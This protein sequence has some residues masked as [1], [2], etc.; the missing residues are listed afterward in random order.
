M[1]IYKIEYTRKKVSD[2]TI[3]P[4][5]MP[6]QAL[7]FLLEHCFPKKENWREKS[8]LL[9][10]DSANIL[11]GYTLIGVGGFENVTVDIKL[12]LK[13][14]LDCNASS[15]ILV[16]NHPANNVLPS[17]ADIVQTGKLKKALGLVDIKLLDHIILGDDKFFS[18]SEEKIVEYNP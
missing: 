5:R 6:S 11:T 2:T 15:V 12:V 1:P 7:P 17:Q 14:A 18:F 16:H 13:A 8:Y 9:L 4:I 10:L 3:G